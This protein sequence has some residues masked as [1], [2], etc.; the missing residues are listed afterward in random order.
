MNTPEHNTAPH[1]SAHTSAHTSAHSSTRLHPESFHKLKVEET[2]DRVVVALHSPDTKNAIDQEMVTELHGVCS[3]LEDNPKILI[4]TGSDGVF[5]SGAN[6]KQLR[7]RRAHDAL[8]GVNSTLFQRIKKLP[9]PVIVALDGYVLGGGAELAL[10]GD[11]R[12]GTHRITVGQPEVGLGIIP[13]A[14]ALWRLRAVV[15]EPM[16][17]RLCLTGELI[18]ADQALSCGF[19]SELHEA[20]ELLPAAH[21]LA[22]RIARQDP[23]AVRLSKHLLSMPESAHPVIDNIAQ[24]ICFESPEKFRR[25][26]SFLNRSQS[27]TQ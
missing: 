27:Q 14:G 15:G 25:M 26:D 11:F 10:A 3:Y 16:A 24:A 13:A 22:D 2:A 4:L 7:E 6:I 1:S 21:A 20:A 18:P 8:R 17:N 19:V 12:I 23:L 5:A 9:M